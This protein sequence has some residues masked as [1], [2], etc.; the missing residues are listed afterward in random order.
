[1]KGV[2]KINNKKKKFRIANLLSTGKENCIPTSK[3]VEYFKSDWRTIRGYIEW[4]RRH[5]AQIISYKGTGGGLCIA[6]SDEEFDEY[7]ENQRLEL[8]TREE[9]LSLM[10]KARY[11]ENKKTL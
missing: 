5:G 1:M 8:K 11:G 3:I 2:G 7:M 10:E 9:T 6:R 4:E